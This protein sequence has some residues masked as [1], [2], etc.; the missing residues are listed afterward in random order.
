MSYKGI[1]YDYTN[2]KIKCFLVKWWSELKRKSNKLLRIMKKHKKSSV[3]ISIVVIVTV[4]RLISPSQEEKLKQYAKERLQ[5]HYGEDFDIFSVSGSYESFTVVA[6]PARDHEILF[7]AGY[8]YGGSKYDN[9]EYIEACTAHMLK[10]N[11]YPR[12][13]QIYGNVIV[14]PYLIGKAPPVFKADKVSMDMLKSYV[15]EPDVYFTIVIDK[16]SYQENKY[17]YEELSD[18]FVSFE[19]DEGIHSTV[20]TFY[21]GADE[22]QQFKEYSSRYLN[23]LSKLDEM[24]LEGDCV[25]AGGFTVKEGKL[26]I[27]K[28][29]YYEKRGDLR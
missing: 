24:A 28:D 23:D 9:D 13:S 18:V 11:I 19:E 17:E 6:A 22:F 25:D 20:H 2:C 1:T 8:K 21:L 4:I 27:T 15:K 12:I 5:N 7:K 26:T 10:D 16:S 14:C 3:I 29:E